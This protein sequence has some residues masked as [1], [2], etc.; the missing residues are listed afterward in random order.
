MF[1]GFVAVACLFGYQLADETPVHDGWASLARIAMGAFPLLIAGYY[2]HNAE[3]LKRLGGLP[4]G[5]GLFLWFI[6]R[7]HQAVRQ[8]LVQPLVLTREGVLRS[9]ERRWP[10]S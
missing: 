8:R 9:L 2:A 3:R 7:V 10:P 4:V 5:K 6:T 1:A